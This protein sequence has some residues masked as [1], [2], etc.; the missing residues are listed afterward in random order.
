MTVTLHVFKQIGWME[1]DIE[2]IL[3]NFYF[4]QIPK[5][6]KNLEVK[7]SKHFWPDLRVDL[8]R[9]LKISPH[10]SPM[11][12]EPTRSTSPLSPLEYSAKDPVSCRLIQN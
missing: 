7:S 12:C 8:R 4:I 6:H 3:I 11:Y 5:T 1:A 2:W 9:Y 10:F